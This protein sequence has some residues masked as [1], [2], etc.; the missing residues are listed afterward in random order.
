MNKNTVKM[1]LSVAAVVGLLMFFSTV[2]TIQQ[3]QHGLLLRLGKLVIDK[4]SN[5]TKIL[6]PGIH[7]KMP[8]ISHYRTFDTRLQ[9]LDIKSS[10]IVTKEKKDVIVDY[11]IKWRIADLPYYFKA[12]G[13]NEFKAENLLSQ[14]LNTSLRAEFGKRTIA[15]VVSGERDDVMEI[16]LKKASQQGKSLGIVVKDVRIKGIDLPPNT[17]NAIYQ[18]M[19]ADME[20]IANRHR[21]DG[22]AQAEAI[23]ANADAKVTVTLATAKSQSKSI[24]AKGQAQAANLYA[25]AYAKNDDFFAFYQSM[26]AYEGSFNNKSDILVLSQDSQFF[27]FF[28][29]S[30]K[31][32]SSRGG[33]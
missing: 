19:R 31:Q 12:T 17:S 14:K 7:F 24:R 23:R 2:F 22:K 15:D 20:K 10:R 28:K 25:S 30:L 13:G 6:N 5:Q 18:R 27:D 8:F 26:K 11:Y 16:L 1:G 21:A 4:K 3:G 32:T 29:K 9:T 33:S